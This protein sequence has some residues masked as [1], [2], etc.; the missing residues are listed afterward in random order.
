MADRE[1]FS[2]S[3]GDLGILSTEEIIDAGENFLNS[4]PNDIKFVPPKPSKKKEEED[5]QNDSSEDNTK[6]DKKPKSKEKDKKPIKEEITPS[7]EIKDSDLFTTLQG[8]EDEDETSE[9]DEEEQVK[10]PKKEEGTNTDNST[11]T[12]EEGPNVYTTVFRELVG[13]GVLSLLDDEESADEIE[14]EGPE[15]LLERFQ[16][17]QRRGAAEVIEKFLARHGDDYRDM[18]QNVFVRGIHPKDY[19]SRYTRIEN[20]K[21]LDLTD[22]ANQ[23]KVVRELYRLEGRSSEYIDKKLQQHKAYGD[24]ETEAKEAQRI[25]I[26]RES[27]EIEK[28]AKEKLALEERKNRIRQEYLGGMNRVLGEKM[29]TKDFD[30]IP[31]DQGFA[32]KTFDYLTR[33]KYQSPDGQYMTEFD[34]DVL[35]LNR[36][37]NHELKVKMAMLLQMAKEDPKLTKLAKRAVAK[38]TNELFKGLKKAAANKK[39]DTTNEEAKPKSWFQ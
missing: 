33:Y 11:T 28:A 32:E 14:L 35:D 21:D 31:V 5:D 24:L 29:K 8:S 12:E 6:D 27:A 7:R 10:L 15:E 36:P 39:K 13:H 4:D 37:E 25:V 18:F 3:A 17:D 34:K 22:E 9:E 16:Y 38:E 30:G 19:L 23:E 2:F 20:V 1:E 26:E